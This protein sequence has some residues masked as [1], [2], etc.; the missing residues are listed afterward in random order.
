MGGPDCIT[1]DV[2]KAAGSAKPLHTIAMKQLIAGQVPA[3]HRGGYAIP[4]YKRGSQ[5]L[6]E[7]YRAIVLEDCTAKIVT[8]MWRTRIEEAFQSITS[9]AQGGA[10]KG[11]GPCSHLARMRVIQQNCRSRHLGFCLLTLDVE[12]A[13]YRSVRQI[14]VSNESADADGATLNRIF[15]RYNLHP[16]MVEDFREELEKGT[17]M[18]EA[19]ANR[20]IQR[21]IHSSFQ[22]SW[23]RIPTSTE[24]LVTL[25]G[26]KPGS[27]A[28]DIL[29]C[30]IMSRYMKNTAQQL[31]ETFGPNGTETCIAW[32]DDVAL[33]VYT[34]ASK[35]KSKAS[36]TLSILCEN[37]NKLALK[38]SLKPSKTEAMLSYQGKGSRHH[39][40]MTQDEPQTLDFNTCEGM[41]T[42][43]IV[44][45]TKYLGAIKDS[46]ANLMPELK[47]MTGQALSAVRPLRSKVIS[48]PNIK[49]EQRKNLVQALA[50]SKATYTC[51]SWPLLKKTEQGQWSTRL[52][53][54]YK[55][56]LPS[57]RGDSNSNHISDLEARAVAGWEEPVDV[58]RNARC[59][60]M[61]SI[62]MG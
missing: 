52:H 58:I 4:L 5:S 8:K 42:V 6:R 9:T 2:Y 7:S 50:M 43:C 20:A 3:R 12:S 48:N 56:V 44:P 37:A 19:N 10:R 54:I 35:I 32:V 17:V 23:C 21:L 13:F 53:S 49:I 36:T 25:T 40:R 61:M 11:I 34:E 16:Q 22:G 14:L 41:Q 24:C 38:V 62:Q 46:E 1:P 29:F 47:M 33:P 57:K 30:V 27:P 55:M 51:S 59:K 28:A 18:Q 60:L 31:R 15:D 45:E 26:T 39:K